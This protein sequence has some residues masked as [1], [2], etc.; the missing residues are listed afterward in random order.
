MS[1]CRAWH[2][3]DGIRPG[4]ADIAVLDPDLCSVLVR[5][6]IVGPNG[7]VDNG[8]ARRSRSAPTF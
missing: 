4:D 7:D 6:A 3:A 5:V 1:R 2:A 8:R